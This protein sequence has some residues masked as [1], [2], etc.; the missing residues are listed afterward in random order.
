M[1][2]KTSRKKTSRK[3][4]SRKKTSRKKTFVSVTPGVIN[5][6]YEIHIP[7]FY[8]SKDFDNSKELMKKLKNNQV[9]NWLNTFLE[10]YKNYK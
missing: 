4:T 2:K 7:K 1:R 8:A 9:D 5:I 10:N 6:K 3:K